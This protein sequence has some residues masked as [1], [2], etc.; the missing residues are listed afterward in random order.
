M[1]GWQMEKKQHEDKRN[2][3][4]KSVS[5]RKFLADSSLFI[6]SAA[7]LLTG[8]GIIGYNVASHNKNKKTT[9]NTNKDQGNLVLLGDKSKF[10]NTDRP[11]K[12]DFE[13]EIQDAWVT[14]SIKGNVYVTK[15]QSGQYLI[16]S[17][18]CTHLG[19]TV[20]FASEKERQTKANLAFRC[21]CHGGEF[22]ELGRN[23]GGPPPRPLNIYRPVVQEDK[24]YFDY[25]SLKQR[26][27]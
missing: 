2:K 14:K 13:T 11:V 26:E 1:E 7:F 9:S 15:E 3:L 12:V 20:P 23:I 18:V 27:S 25:N 8:A 17:P 5:R 4:P 24:L 6:G 22:D 16:M 21:P 19:C 10:E